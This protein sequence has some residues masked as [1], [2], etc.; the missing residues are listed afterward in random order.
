MP[1]AA[2]LA[3]YRHRS[4]VCSRFLLLLY[5]QISACLLLFF[6]DI[7]PERIMLTRNGTVKLGDFG[8]SKPLC[9]EKMRSECRSPVGATEF[10]CVEKLFNRHKARSLDAC[11]TYA[12]DADMWSIGVLV[13]A[14]VCYFP[15]EKCQKLPRNFALI[16]DEQ[17]MPFEWLTS[18]MVV[19]TFVLFYIDFFPAANFSNYARDFK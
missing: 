4:S 6:S 17:Q 2:L 7:Q 13:L 5:L 16:L 19:R 8:Q 18:D 10:M 12:Y 11:R 3:H 15:E 1:S 9:T 14:M